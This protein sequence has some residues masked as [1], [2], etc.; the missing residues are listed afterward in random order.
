VTAKRSLLYTYVGSEGSFHDASKLEDVPQEVRRVVRVVD[1]ALP[2]AARPDG[3]RVFVADL[4]R[5][6][7]QGRYPVRLVDRTAFETLALAQLSPGDT[8]PLARPLPAAGPDSGKVGKD[9]GVVIY[10]TSWCGACR[11]ARAFLKDRGVAFVDKD[12]EKDPAAA[13]ELSQKCARAGVSPTGVPVIDVHGTL[14]LG[15]EPGRLSTL[16]GGRGVQL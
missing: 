5:A 14:L 3:A 8:S 10:G 4:R 7:D 15:F 2:P 1:P 12:V 16:L 6:D 13:A 9:E 11:K